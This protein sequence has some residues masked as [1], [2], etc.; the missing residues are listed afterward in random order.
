MISLTTST[1]D[2]AISSC[3]VFAYAER[4]CWGLRH[5]VDHF[6]SFALLVSP[7]LVAKRW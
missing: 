4:C 2:F 3:L 5:L 7:I 1:E 6:A